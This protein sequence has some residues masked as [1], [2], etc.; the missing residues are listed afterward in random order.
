MIRIKP[1]LR[2]MREVATRV[3]WLLLTVMVSEKMA[4]GITPNILTWWKVVLHQKNL[5]REAA[6]TLDRVEG[7]H[8]AL[9]CVDPGVSF[10]LFL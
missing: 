10:W 9:V 8:M 2:A 3:D 4:L 6:G 5:E 1:S 7:S